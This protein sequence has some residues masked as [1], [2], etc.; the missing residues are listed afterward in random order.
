MRA[1]RRDRHGPDGEDR[2]IDSTTTTE[3]KS[4]GTTKV[5]VPEAAIGRPV[6][7][8][9]PRALDDLEVRA[10]SAP[11]TR[12]PFFDVIAAVA[13]PGYVSE[14]RPRHPARAVMDLKRG[15]PPG[16]VV[17]GEPGPVGF[18]IARTFPTDAPGQVVVPAWRR[19]GAAAALALAAAL[20]GRHATAVLP[21][22][23]DP[24]TVEVARIVD[25]LEAPVRIEPWGKTGID[26]A[27]AAF[28]EQARALAEGGVDLFILET[29][30][31]V[32]ELLAAVRAVRRVSTLPIVAQM[33]TEDDGNSLDGTPPEAFAPQLEAAGADV[34]GVNCCVGPA[35][36]LETVERMASATSP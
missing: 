30:R 2:E 35:S 33:T 7:H 5:E 18:W 21:A 9:D 22:P 15:I 12:P 23:V 27:E 24:T 11:I 29:F 6:L 36:M 16:A 3:F 34:I 13:G 28:A 10:S 1:D 17:T 31:D 8:V 14:D 4:V 26:D 19:E 32:N 25:A 20:G